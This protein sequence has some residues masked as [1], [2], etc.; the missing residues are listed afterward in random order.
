MVNQ[1]VTRHPVFFATF[2]TCVVALGSAAFLGK[3]GVVGSDSDDLM[4]L[5]QVRDLMAGQS[6]F[7]T[8]QYRLGPDGGTLMHWSRIPDIPLVVLIGFFNMFV[9][10]SFAEALAISLWPPMSAGLAFLGLVTGARNLA[11]PKAVPFAVIVGL[12]TL[13]LYYRFHVGALDHH[14]LQIAFLLIA[15][16]FMT[17]PS[18]RFSSF[19]VAGAAVA[20]SMAIG[21][22]VYI[23]VAIIC[24]AVPLLWLVRGQVVSQA[25]SG[26]GVGFGATSVALFFATTSTAQ[27]LAV[28]CDA[29]SSIN[30]AVAGVGGLLLLIASHERMQ[31][32]FRWRFLVLLVMGT[33]TGVLLIT[34]SPQCLASPLSTLP[35]EVKTLWLDLILEAR[36]VLALTDLNPLIP[37]T[38]LG[39]PLLTLVLLLRDI[40]IGRNPFANLLF[41][42][43][44]G[45]A[46]ATTLVQ[47]RFSVFAHMFCLFA[48][49]CW[50]LQVYQHS[51][52]YRFKLLPATLVVFVSTQTA[53]AL[54]AA[55]YNVTSE[56]KRLDIESSSRCMSAV[57]MTRLKSLPSGTILARP[58]LSPLILDQTE[59]R[60]LN[61]NYHRNVNGIEMA[62]RIFMSNPQS[63]PDLLR[64]AGVTYLVVCPKGGQDSFLANRAPDGLAAGLLAGKSYSFLEP[65]E[66]ADT[67]SAAGDSAKMFRVVF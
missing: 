62:V 21:A 45:A 1:L 67:S 54:P 49:V 26:F 19:L 60:V 56:T 28:Y 63:S 41:A 11:G 55:V 31:G 16:G 14:N 10:A 33:S 27:Y 64:E 22:E 17:D 42:A 18:H 13:A 38:Y 40:R 61:G 53:W 4:R 46:I 43:L 24:V 65:I 50:A 7:D 6:F 32:S 9:S 47:V 59:H 5:I 51:Q 34:A 52:K 36:P 37:V 39:A 12:A 25:L 29:F 15:L 30:A 48:W 8:Y 20:V 2:I 58:G 57:S 23:F 3:F 66:D 44:I 35:N